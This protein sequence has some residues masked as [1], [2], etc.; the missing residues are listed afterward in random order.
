MDL[1]AR[2]RSE[3]WRVYGQICR[4]THRMRPPKKPATPRHTARHRAI[5]GSEGPTGRR[6]WA[7]LRRGTFPPPP[8]TPTPGRP[9]GVLPMKPKRILRVL[10][11][12]AALAV[13]TAP[14]V[15]FSAFAQGPPREKSNP[16]NRKKQEKIKAAQEGSKKAKERKELTEARSPGKPRQQDQARET[17]R[18]QG[19]PTRQGHQTER[20]GRRQGE[21]EGVSGGDPCGIGLQM[22]RV[23]HGAWPRAASPSPA[24]ADSVRSPR[25]RIGP[26]TIALLQSE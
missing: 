3:L 19:R 23:P 26:E 13:A 10:L 22:T 4:K 18:R 17:R 2:D 12:L 5:H 11:T 20:E 15:E 1:A 8:P 14:A 24:R 21:G 25:S 16:D 6:L 7:I 9:Q